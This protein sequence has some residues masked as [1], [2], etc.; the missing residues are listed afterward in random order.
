MQDGLLRIWIGI[1]HEL[2]NGAIGPIPYA[3][4]RRIVVAFMPGTVD[5]Q[6]GTGAVQANVPLPIGT[7]ASRIQ[8]VG[9]DNNQWR[10]GTDTHV[11]DVIDGD[12]PGYIIV[13]ETPP[14]PPAPQ[15]APGSG[16]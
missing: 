12:K 3:E 1:E 13:R 16:N 14:A 15:L 5:D 6:R 2:R 10:V 8:R 11:L 9:R 4:A 7:K